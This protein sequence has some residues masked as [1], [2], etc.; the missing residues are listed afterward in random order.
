MTRK[1]VMTLAAAFAVA[2]P[3]ALSLAPR[4]VL[5]FDV[6]SDCSCATG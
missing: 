2:A 4:A 3:L 1:T 6:T 5:P